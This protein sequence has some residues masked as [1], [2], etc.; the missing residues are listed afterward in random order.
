MTC[1][2]VSKS[3]TGVRDRHFSHV[4]L[5]SAVGIFTAID[6]VWKKNHKK[7][8]LNDCQSYLSI[9]KCEP[10]SLRSERQQFEFEFH[11][12]QRRGNVVR[13][14]I[15]FG[16]GRMLKFESMRDF[17]RHVFQKQINNSLELHK[18]YGSSD[19]SR[20]EGPTT[21]VLTIYHC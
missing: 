5:K 10:S 4:A 21:G 9:I 15:E 6:R 17:I 18:L 19:P 11:V 7:K 8:V 1:G 3:I 16:D 13:A 14:I 20:A 12:F 2:I